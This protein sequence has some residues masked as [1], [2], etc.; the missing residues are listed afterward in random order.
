MQIKVTALRDHSGYKK[1]EV[2]E[3]DSSAVNF[4]LRNN[5]VKLYEAPKAKK[6]RKKT[7]PAPKSTKE[8]KT[9]YK[10]KAK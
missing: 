6:P 2:Y 3:I 8:D 10:T 1:D 7:A 5:L 9:A 4:R